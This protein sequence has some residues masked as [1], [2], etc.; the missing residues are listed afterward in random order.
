[1]IVHGGGGAEA[2][3]GPGCARCH[4]PTTPSRAA[5]AGGAQ[6]PWAAECWLSGPAAPAAQA[7]RQCGGRAGT[8][9]PRGGGGTSEPG[10]T[11]GRLRGLRGRFPEP[12][13]GRV[14]G[15]PA[16]SVPQRAAGG[17][18]LGPP[19]ARGRVGAALWL[20]GP[21]RVRCPL[22]RAGPP[23][24]GHAGQAGGRRGRAGGACPA[25]A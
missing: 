12:P 8:L 22:R 18:A 1:M 19:P 14:T 16:F 13:A 7:P 20:E 25:A 21:A 5:A 6:A 3:A 24:R 10:A 17:A 23:G 9:P 11:A 2:G 4:V 15:G